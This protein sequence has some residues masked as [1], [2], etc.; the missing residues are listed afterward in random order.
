MR[1]VFNVICQQQKRGKQRFTGTLILL[2][3]Y[4]RLKTSQSE[5]F[6]AKYSA[7]QN[8]NAFYVRKSISRVVNHKN[9]A[10]DINRE[11]RPGSVSVTTLMR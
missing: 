2:K 8:D 1:R 6:E 3:K 10:C 7:L 5:L 11:G 4:F 9:P